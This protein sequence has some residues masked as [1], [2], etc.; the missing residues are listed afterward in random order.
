MCNFNPVGSLSNVAS[1]FAN[2]LI[3]TILKRVEMAKEVVAN[4]S[5]NKHRAELFWDSGH[6]QYHYFSIIM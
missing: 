4:E 1:V 6:A 2:G 5:Y 3:R